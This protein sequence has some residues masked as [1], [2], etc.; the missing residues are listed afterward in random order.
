MDLHDG[1]GQENTLFSLPLGPLTSP[2]LVLDMMTLGVG[3]GGTRGHGSC[4]SQASKSSW[5]LERWKTNY[6]FKTE[7]G[8]KT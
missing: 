6:K 3:R 8:L 4:D 1:K 5:N 2:I 7:M